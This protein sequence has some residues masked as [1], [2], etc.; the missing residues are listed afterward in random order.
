MV[1]LTEEEL[2]VLRDVLDLSVEEFEDAKQDDTGEF[3]ND[4]DEL[5][6]SA[7]GYDE[8]IRILKGIREKVTS[9]DGGGC[10]T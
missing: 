3:L 5:L 7:A 8:T 9:D 4:I 1:P 6:R 10:A 2:V